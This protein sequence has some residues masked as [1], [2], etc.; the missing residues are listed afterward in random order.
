MTLD[1]IENQGAMSLAR[2]FDKSGKRT[3]GMLRCDVK[4]TRKGVL[5][6]ADRVTDAD[7]FERWKQIITGEDRPHRLI[8]G[9]YLTMQRRPNA[10]ATWQECLQ[11]ENKYFEHNPTWSELGHAFQKFVGTLELRKKLSLELS[12]LIKSRSIFH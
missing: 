11:N 1:D 3:I 6:K 7:N 12:R 9:Y 2:R 10:I 8:H 5:T 4:L